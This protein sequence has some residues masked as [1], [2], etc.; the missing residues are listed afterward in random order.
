M[1]DS[2]NPARKASASYSARL[3]GGS[4]LTADPVD[5]GSVVVSAPHRQLAPD[6]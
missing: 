2:E 4:A 6:E 5:D 3:E 1:S